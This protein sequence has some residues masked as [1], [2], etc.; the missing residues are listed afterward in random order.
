[1]TDGSRQQSFDVVEH[2]SDEE[3]PPDDKRQQPG[4]IASRAGLSAAS[5]VR[6]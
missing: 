4:H 1:M 2:V 3:P 5:G 6:Q